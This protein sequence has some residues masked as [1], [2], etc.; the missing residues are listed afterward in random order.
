MGAI[1]IKRV[2]VTLCLLERGCM[3]AEIDNATMTCVRSATK[4][5]VVL[6]KEMLMK[7]M[8][9]VVLMK[10]MLQNPLKHT[11]NPLKKTQNPLNLKQT[12]PMMIK[13]TKVIKM[14]KIRTILILILLIRRMVLRRTFWRRKAFD[15][16]N[17]LMRTFWWMMMRSWSYSWMIMWTFW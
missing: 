17:L 11:Q 6:M 2:A 8:L 13:L 1:T 14:L 10:E 5:P 15:N 12:Q 16:K 4:Q 7:E 3:D 9:Q